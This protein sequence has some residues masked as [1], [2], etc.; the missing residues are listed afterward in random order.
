MKAVNSLGQKFKSCCEPFWW[1]VDGKSH[2]TTNTFHTSN[3]GIIDRFWL[4]VGEDD[5]W[6]THC[7]FCGTK[8]KLAK[9]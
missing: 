8:I 7:P 5:Y 2:L 9:E 6:A 1:F 3:A 4:H